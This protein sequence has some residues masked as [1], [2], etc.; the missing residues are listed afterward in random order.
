MLK[1]ICLYSLFDIYI[2]IDSI[3]NSIDHATS[4]V[5]DGATELLK[6]SQYQHRY[7]RK[8]CFLV[9]IAAI[10]VSVLIA[11]LVTTIKGHK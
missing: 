5:E 3:E 11:I 7:R 4:H 10:I 9:V 1:E 8:L 6:A 2:F